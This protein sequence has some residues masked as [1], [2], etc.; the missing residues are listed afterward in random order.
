MHGSG[1]IQYR[2]A[3]PIWLIQPFRMAEKIASL[4]ISEVY[5]IS[6]I[7]TKCQVSFQICTIK[8]IFYANSLHY[9]YYYYYYYYHYTHFVYTNYTGVDKFEIFTIY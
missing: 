1:D 8:V 4:E 9:Y 2:L 5:N 6:N 7:C 3:K